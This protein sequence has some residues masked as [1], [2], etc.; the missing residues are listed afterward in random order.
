MPEL[1][2]VSLPSVSS[3]NVF[4]CVLST[5][6]LYLLRVSS[7]S[8][9]ILC[10]MCVCVSGTDWPCLLRVSSCSV[11]ILFNVCLYVSG[12]NWQCL[13][14]VSSCSV[15]ILFNVCLCVSGTDW[16]CLLRVST[17]VSCGM[18]PMTQ[19]CWLEFTNMVWEAGKLSR[20]TP[21]WDCPTRSANCYMCLQWKW[22]VSGWQHHK[23]MT[24]I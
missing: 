5:D 14:R 4:L 19:C 10:L 18:P 9:C 22:D 3:R 8:V 6:W 16:P 1:T 17:G 23:T 12:T 2:I 13:L 11:C 20:W 7:Y 24:L 15:C 21:L